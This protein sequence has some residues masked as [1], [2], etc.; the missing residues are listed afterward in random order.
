VP[1]FLFT[2]GHERE[3]APLSAIT[4]VS[5]R[6]EPDDVGDLLAIAQ[7]RLLAGPK[8]TSSYWAAFSGDMPSILMLSQ[9]E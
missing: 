8:P 7:A 5:M 3:L 9:D 4:G 6:H 1:I 2:D